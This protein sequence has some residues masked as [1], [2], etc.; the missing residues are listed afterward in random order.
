MR[1]RTV[2][3]V[4]FFSSKGRQAH[5]WCVEGTSPLC[6][7]FRPDFPDIWED[8][9]V[10]SVVMVDTQ[11]AGVVLRVTEMAVRATDEA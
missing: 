10:G 11:D 6:I 2:G 4:L 1:T 3:T 9:S 8:L 7:A 5:I